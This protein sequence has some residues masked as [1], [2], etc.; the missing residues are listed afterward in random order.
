MRST[1]LRFL[2]PTLFVGLAFG[3]CTPE[4]ED[5][6]EACG[7]IIIT[8]INPETEFSQ[9]TTF[10]VVGE[11]GYPIELPADLPD[12]TLKNILAANSAARTSLIGQGLVEVDPE[13]EEPDVWL[14]SLA[15]T[16]TQIGYVWACVPGYVW[17]GWSAW[18]Y[19]C[20]WWDEVPVTYEV[21]TVVVGLAQLD[22]DTAGEVVFGGAVQ[23]VL[24]CDDPR[25]RI[26]TAVTK[27]F[28][29]Y[30]VPIE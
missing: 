24:F 29:Q 30:P 16:E 3:A 23:G 20:P 1:S 13:F 4:E 2:G 5:P 17:W 26:T 8:R 14:F 11:D 9:I 15:A 7:D 12:D 10:A 6:N 27:I 25:Q 22:D 18:D 21:G 28:A 19:Y